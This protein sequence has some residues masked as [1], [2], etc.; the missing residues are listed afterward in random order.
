MKEIGGYFGLETFTGR[1]YHE[2]LLAL[3]NGRN[4]LLYLLKARRIRKLYL[5]R[6]LCDFVSNLCDRYGYAYEYYSIDREFMPVFSKELGEDE[7]LYVV[8]FYGQLSNETAVQLKACYGNII[9]DNI[10]AFFQKPVEGIDTIYSCR[11]FFGVPDGG[12]LATDA[13]L[14]EELRLDVSKDRMRHILGRF[15]G[16]ASDYHGD[17]KANDHAFK[18]LELRR[19][20]E[21]THNLLRAVD[22]EAARQKRNENY[23]LLE[24][25]L[26]ERNGL[27]LSIPDGPYAYPFYC[28]N[29]MALKKKLAEKK[30]FVATLWPNVLEN[31]NELEKA[32]T[33]NIL[34]L[35]CDQRYGA[36][37]MQ[38]IIIEISCLM[39]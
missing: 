8:N 21:L 25:A 17:F 4:A 34:P 27:K 24:A 2:G 16:S 28:E 36:E 33:E 14:E 26:G 35:P 20:S 7:Y 39:D 31:G 1:E 10:H 3:N 22:Y 37:D 11:K 23:G 18:E 12:Y 32:Y 19:M 29:G 13:V 38:R 6:F 9:F 15:E 5:P 30:I